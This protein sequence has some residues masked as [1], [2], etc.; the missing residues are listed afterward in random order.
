MIEG[1]QYLDIPTRDLRRRARDL[2]RDASRPPFRA[3]PFNV[4]LIGGIVLAEGKIAE[5]KTG[6]GKTI[7]GPLAC[8]LARLPSKKQVHVVTV[9]R[10]PRAARP[11]LDGPVLPRARAHRRRDP[12]AAHA[13]ARGQAVR[14]RLRHHLRHQQRVRLRLPARQ[15]E[16]ARSR[17]RCRSGRGLRDRRRGRLDPHRRGA[18]AAHHLGPAHANGSRATTSPTRSRA[19]SSSR[20]ARLGQRKRRL[21]KTARGTYRRRCEGDIRNARDKCLACRRC[22]RPTWTRARKDSQPQ[23]RAATASS[24]STRSNST[25]RRATLTHDGVEEAQRFA[26]SID[27]TVGSFYVGDNIDMPH[28]VEQA[29]R[30]HI[31]LPA[32]SRDYVVAADETGVEGVVI[33]DQNTGRKMVGRQWSDGLHQAVEAKEKVQDQGRDADDGDDHRSRTTSSSTSASPA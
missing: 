14:L 24:S 9:E 26:K 10:L 6:E 25:R 33:V 4:Q 1:W 27:P 3:R 15:H 12:P 5:M 28:L 17:T 19:T 13:G 31:R 20:Q 21:P 29:V 18:H 2:S 22:R 23:R 16:V 30:A 11:R 8:Y 7:V 32:R